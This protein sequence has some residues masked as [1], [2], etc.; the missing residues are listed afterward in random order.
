VQRLL[1]RLVPPGLT[2]TASQQRDVRAVRVLEQAGTARAKKLLEVLAK[3]SPGW[4]VRQEAKEAL[5][6][7]ARATASRDGL[8]AVLVLR[9]ARPRAQ[10]LHLQQE[11]HLA[12]ML[13]LIVPAMQDAIPQGA[14]ISRV[15]VGRR[16]IEGIIGNGGEPVPHDPELRNKAIQ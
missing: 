3:E 7:L 13:G 16:P 5:Q 2:L 11:V 9:S 14:G 1:R 12:L 8:Q 10:A 6:R 15:S 4:W